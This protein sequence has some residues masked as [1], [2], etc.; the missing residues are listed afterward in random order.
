MGNEPHSDHTA[1]VTAV[2]ADYVSMATFVSCLPDWLP[3]P[4]AIVASGNAAQPGVVQA[5]AN[6]ALM[7]VVALDRPRH[8]EPGI[9]YV[10]LAARAPVIGDGFAYPSGHVAR[11]AGTTGFLRSAALTYGARTLAVFLE[12]SLPLADGFARRL[13]W[14]GVRVFARAPDDHVLVRTGVVRNYHS[15]E[16]LCE[17]VGIA[18]AHRLSLL[19]V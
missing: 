19:A 2:A 7:P 3:V 8:L 11:D 16:I 1:V 6:E 4:V 15:T 9:C 18:S 10:G 13:G 14:A 5:L 17:A 12:G